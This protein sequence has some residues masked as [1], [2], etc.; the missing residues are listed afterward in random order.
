MT[1]L[2]LH[3][4][5]PDCGDVN[6]NNNG[7][8]GEENPN[9]PQPTKYTVTLTVAGN[10]TATGAGEY[11]SGASVTLT[12][13]PGAD[14]KFLAWEG[15][16]GG[17]STTRTFTIT[18]NMLITAHFVHKRQPYTARSD[19]KKFKNN[20]TQT[21]QTQLA[22][23]CVASIMAYIKQVLCG[24][25]FSDGDYML[26]YLQK[27]KTWL[28]ETGMPLEHV[29]PFMSEHFAIGTFTSW[30]SAIDAGRVVATDVPSDISGSTH[31]VLV[32]GYGADGSLIYMDPEMGSLMRA[33][34]DYIAGNI[35]M[36]INKCQ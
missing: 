20:F 22:N 30:Q 7:G 27:Y 14:Y 16:I 25:A 4:I 31:A 35:K 9:P 36:V 12:A 33:D 10:G 2:R 8:N 18:Q 1:I 28:H 6:C 3:I 19:D 34:A 11:N 24:G 17:T 23:T 5:D 21:M 13:T 15:D 29:Q 32:V 26:K